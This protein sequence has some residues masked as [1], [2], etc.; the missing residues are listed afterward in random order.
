[1]TN[2]K[3]SFQNFFEE[4][5]KRQ[6]TSRERESPSQSG[7]FGLSTMIYNRHMMMIYEDQHGIVVSVELLWLLHQVKEQPPKYIRC[8]IIQTQSKPTLF[9]NLK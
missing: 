2:Y 3:A 4:I 7:T 8:S 1:M 5:I 6:P 9:I